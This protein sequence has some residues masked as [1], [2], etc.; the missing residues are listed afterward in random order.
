VDRQFGVV[1]MMR[2]RFVAREAGE[3]AGTLT[4]RTLT[5]DA[6]SLTVNAAAEG[7]EV[8]VQ[9][10]TAAGEPIPGFRFEEC[11]P[12]AADALAAPVEWKQSLATLRGRPIR[13]EFS[14]RNARLFAFEL[15]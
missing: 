14:L 1:K 11:R 12:I 4:T 15:H 8:R 2:D 5:L 3:K 6:Q 13:L 10:T 7:G 9:A